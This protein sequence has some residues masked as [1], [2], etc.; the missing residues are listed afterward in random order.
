MRA[1]SDLAEE[2]A[3]AEG[4]VVADLVARNSIVLV[5]DSIL[6]AAKQTPHQVEAG[7]SKENKNN[8]L[9]IQNDWL[10][11]SNKIGSIVVK[12][13][14]TITFETVKEMQI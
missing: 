7:M 14:K 12:R 11:G 1:V 6:V 5:S 8:D 2:P 13:I 9:H 3:G 4:P 10:R